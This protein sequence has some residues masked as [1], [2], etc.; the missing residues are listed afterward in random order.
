MSV[1]PGCIYVPMCVLDT[2]SSGGQ[3]K[4]IGS[5]ESCITDECTPLCGFWESNLGPERVASALNY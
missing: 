4:G 1:L 2:F 3:K 5:P